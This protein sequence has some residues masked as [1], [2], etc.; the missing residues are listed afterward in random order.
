MTAP[1]EFP[2]GTDN[3]VEDVPCGFCGATSGRVIGV[4]R[5]RYR[6]RHC[7]RC[8]LL[9]TSSRPVGDATHAHFEG[10]YLISEDGLSTDF[11]DRRR[12]ALQRVGIAVS[13]RHPAGGSILDVGAAGGELL[14]QF[15]DDR[16]HK[17]ALEP[18]RLGAAQL[19][20]RGLEVIC[21]FYPSDRLDG[22]RFDVIAM[23][24]VIMLMPDPLMS[25]R[26][27]RQQLRPGGTLAV[28][29]PGY[30]YRNALHVGP[31]PLIRGR[32]WTDLNASIHLYFFSDR[33]LRAM[34]DEAGLVV[35]DVV[36][37][38]PSR[39]A[40][41]LGRLQSVAGAA[42]E[43]LPG[44]RSGR[45]SLAAKYLYLAEPNGLSS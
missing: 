5:H 29:I 12:A 22:R 28:E 20:Q 26:A 10:D 11:G 8:G 18:S 31:V 40:G 23:M 25:L 44:V 3:D 37:L 9:Y 17:V 27:A 33:T 1:Q 41:V 2:G 35:K 14:R 36:P 45:P 16:W 39:R 32:G 4:F 15:A 19:Q 13:R 6:I 7:G 43:R 38:P 21:D 42:T 34:V 30:A 24:D